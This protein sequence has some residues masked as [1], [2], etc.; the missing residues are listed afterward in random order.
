[1][2]PGK[3]E[4]TM[5]AECVEPHSWWNPRA[6]MGTCMHIHNHTHITH[7]YHYTHEQAYKPTV[8]DDASIPTCIPRHAL[9]YT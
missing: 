2:K 6:Q 3:V 7:A 5:P 4:Q 9:L 1:M 8:P